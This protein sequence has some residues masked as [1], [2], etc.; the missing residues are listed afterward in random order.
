MANAASRPSLTGCQSQLA[1][2]QDAQCSDRVFVV[3]Q[4]L[5]VLEWCHEKQQHAVQHV[6]E[7]RQHAYLHL[8]VMIDVQ[9]SLPELD[10]FQGHK[11]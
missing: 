7:T 3:S 6:I 5:P 9:E 8:S 10:N 4:T 1:R 2:P 11:Q